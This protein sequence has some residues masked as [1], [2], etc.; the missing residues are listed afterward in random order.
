MV[1]DDAV[2]GLLLALGL[3]AGQLLATR[4]ISALKVSV[5]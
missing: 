1:G 2:A 5:S 3:G 4:A